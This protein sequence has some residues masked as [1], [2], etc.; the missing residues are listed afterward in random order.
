MI[1][2]GIQ[3]NGM[4]GNS[5][6]RLVKAKEMVDLALARLKDDPAILFPIAAKQP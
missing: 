2:Q 3:V 4:I 6:I 1:E 5:V